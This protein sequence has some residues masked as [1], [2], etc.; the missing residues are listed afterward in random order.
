M[1]YPP[2]VSGSRRSDPAKM[3]SKSIVFKKICKDKSVSRDRLSDGAL[4]G[5]NLRSSR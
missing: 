1:F 5:C 3:A 4:R 2:F